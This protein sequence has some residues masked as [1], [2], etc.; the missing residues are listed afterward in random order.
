[1][2]RIAEFIAS[3]SQC[4]SGG[5][6]QFAVELQ[7]FGTAFEGTVIN[8]R[9]AVWQGDAG[10]SHATGEGVHFDLCDALRHDNAGQAGTA[11]ESRSP[12]AGNALRQHDSLQAGAALESAGADGHNR[13]ALDFRGDLKR[14]STSGIPGNRQRLARQR[15]LQAEPIIRLAEHADAGGIS[16]KRQCFGRIAVDIAV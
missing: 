14:G 10:Q 2:I 4:P 1:M 8:I 16:H 3:L 11:L 6:G 9:N 12:N 5:S 15:T 13:Y 7:A